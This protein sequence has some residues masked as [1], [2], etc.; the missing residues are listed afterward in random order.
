MANYMQIPEERALWSFDTETLAVT[1]T[2]P[3]L[4]VYINYLDPSDSQQWGRGWRHGGAHTT[5]WPTK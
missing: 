2:A 5:R 4:L 1:E 3:L